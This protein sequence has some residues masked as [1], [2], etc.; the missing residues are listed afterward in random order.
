M[1]P[2]LSAHAQVHGSFDF[3]ATPLT[4]PGTKII[5]HE[6]PSVRGSWSLRVIDGWYIG[7]TPS[8]TDVFGS[9]PT[10]LIIVTFQTQSNFSHTT[11]TC[12]FFLQRTM[13]SVQSKN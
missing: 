10:K 9:M 7:Y 1:K 6:K 12:I 3:N 2:K 11:V 5:I 13:P 8:A 4:P